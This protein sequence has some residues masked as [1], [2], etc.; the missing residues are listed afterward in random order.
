[1]TYREACKVLNIHPGR[2]LVS[3]KM[4]AGFVLN[5]VVKAAPLRLTVAATTILRTTPQGAKA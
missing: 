4:Q 2:G 3:A 1:M 5:T